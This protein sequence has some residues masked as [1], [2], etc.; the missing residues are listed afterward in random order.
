MAEITLPEE[1]VMLSKVQRERGEEDE[2]ERER[3]REREA[4]PL[5]GEKET[6]V[7][8]RV[9]DPVESVMREYGVEFER[10]N[11][12]ELKERRAISIKKS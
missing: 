2:R 1:T 9:S 6:G 3:E 11:E 10:T 5:E 7:R 8:V 4:I 12:I